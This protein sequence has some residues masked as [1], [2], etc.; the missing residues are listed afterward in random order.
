MFAYI[1]V[2]KD[3]ITTYNTFLSWGYI[4]YAKRRVPFTGNQEKKTNR[5][6]K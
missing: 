4:A 2:R 5:K 6:E 3:H 1:I